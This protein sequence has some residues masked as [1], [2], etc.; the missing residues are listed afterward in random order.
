MKMKFFEKQLFLIITFPLMDDFILNI[1]KINDFWSFGLH[2]PFLALDEVLSKDQPLML[3]IKQNWAVSNNQM[4]KPISESESPTYSTVL[5]VLMSI[6]LWLMKSR[7]GPPFYA[8]YSCWWSLKAD[9]PLSR[10]FTTFETQRRRILIPKKI[11]FL[12]NTT[13]L[14]AVIHTILLIWHP[15]FNP[16]IALLKYERTVHCVPQTFLTW[17]HWEEEMWPLQRLMADLRPFIM[18]TARNCSNG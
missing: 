1:D 12:G 14:L 18:K 10:I 7:G 16:G 8:L 9:P 4:S 5:W 2:W 6:V 17:H 11:G 15:L 3:N 13:L